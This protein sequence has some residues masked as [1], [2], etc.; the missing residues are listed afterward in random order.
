MMR[1]L[2][3]MARFGDA[4]EC[5]KTRIDVE[6][7]GTIDRIYPPHVHLYHTTE[8]KMD[9]DKR[10]FTIEINLAY[11]MW[12]GHIVPCRIRDKKKK[13]DRMDSTETSWEGYKTYLQTFEEFICDGDVNKRYAG[14]I[15]NIAVAIRVFNEEA[16]LSQL[17]KEDKEL[18]RKK[19]GD[20]SQ[21][22]KF[23]VVLYCYGR[24]IRR[25][26]R[27]YFTQEQIDRFK[28]IFE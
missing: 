6:L 11:Y 2:N 28:E 10:S 26:F 12:T 19:I 20:Y 3:E 24:K 9:R 13:V 15:D 7:H 16:N 14:C 8:R 4:L 27:K 22:D 1:R 17:H 23:L 18:I 5:G 25:Q 21:N